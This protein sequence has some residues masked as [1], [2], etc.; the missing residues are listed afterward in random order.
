M[1]S[2][3]TASFHSGR[4]FSARHATKEVVLRALQRVAE[5]TTNRNRVPRYTLCVNPYA[6]DFSTGI[7][8][9]LA[10][11]LIAAPWAAGS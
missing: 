2:T 7:S 1:W 9:T 6:A 5:A 8:V 10:S 4:R 11:S 3:A